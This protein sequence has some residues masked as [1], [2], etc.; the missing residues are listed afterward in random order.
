LLAAVGVDMTVL[1]VVELEVIAHLPEL[2]VAVQAQKQQ[3]QLL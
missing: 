1:V 2:A 3:L